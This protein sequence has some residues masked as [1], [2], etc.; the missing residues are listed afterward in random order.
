MSDK[1]PEIKER[2]TINVQI[3]YGFIDEGFQTINFNESEAKDYFK[4]FKSSL[5]YYNTHIDEFES[6]GPR[7]EVARSYLEKF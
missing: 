5:D 4:E 1:L 2:F 7:G 3:A 6:S